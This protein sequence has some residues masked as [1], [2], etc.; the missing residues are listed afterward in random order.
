MIGCEKDVMVVI[1]F[2]VSGVEVI[3]EVIG[4]VL[5]LFGI[6]VVKEDIR[7]FFDG[8]WEDYSDGINVG[9]VVYLLIFGR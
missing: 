7:M 1:D 6:G 2:Y 5:S 3:L 4:D 9:Y 8:S